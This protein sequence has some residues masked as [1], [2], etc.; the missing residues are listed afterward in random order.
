MNRF[1][2]PTPLGTEAQLEYLAAD[3]RIIRHG[4]FVTCAVT[5]E[6][7]A[8]AE[9]RYWSAPLQEAYRGPEA[10]LIRK[11]QLMAREAT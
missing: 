6:P 9:L 7:I 10:V 8:L 4:S 2:R 3:Y 1:E 11:R 5:H